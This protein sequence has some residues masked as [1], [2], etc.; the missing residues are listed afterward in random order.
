MRKLL[1]LT[2]ALVA[3]GV[4]GTEKAEA[5]RL[6][7]HPKSF[8]HQLALAK[9]QLKHDKQEGLNHWVARDRAWIVKLKKLMH[10]VPRYPAWLVNAFLCIHRYEGSWTDPNDPYWGGL[11][12]DRGFMYT[13]GSWAIKK[14]KGFANVWPPAVQISVAIAAHRSGRGFGPW[15]NTARYCGLM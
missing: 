11:Q 9:L 7:G 13:Y 3:A 6:S 4:T 10:P 15:P 1:M 14:Y 12:M 2:A 5:H 8:K